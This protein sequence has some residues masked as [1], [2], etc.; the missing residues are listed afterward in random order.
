VEV[1][2]NLKVY[3]SGCNIIDVKFIEI[4]KELEKL[5]YKLDESYDLTGFRFRLIHEDDCIT[6]KGKLNS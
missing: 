4:L 2:Y 3:W 5:V 6:I 1:I